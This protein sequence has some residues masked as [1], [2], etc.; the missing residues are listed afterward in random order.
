M[1][2]SRARAGPRPSAPNAETAWRRARPSGNLPAFE[3]SVSSHRPLSLPRR[4]RSRAGARG[5]ISK[6][7]HCGFGVGRARCPPFGSVWHERRASVP[8]RLGRW[9]GPIPRIALLVAPHPGDEARADHR[10]AGAQRVPVAVHRPLDLALLASLPGATRRGWGR[11]EPATPTVRGDT[12][13]PARTVGADLRGALGRAGNGP[14]PFPERIPVEPPRRLA[15]PDAAAHSDRLRDRR[16]WRFVPRGV[17]FDGIVQRGR[18]ARGGWEVGPL[19]QTRSV[20]TTAGRGRGC[21]LGSFLLAPARTS[22]R[23]FECGAGATE[24]SAKRHLGRRGGLEPFRQ[25]TPTLRARA[26]DKAGLARVA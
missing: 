14:G 10:L 9:N 8:H 4:D 21:L 7:R 6:A 18:V 11:L 20:A 2:K 12:L 15:K 22:R 25:T 1:P 5:G 26:G 13:E 16:L 3:A 19:R 17:V 23:E 24:H